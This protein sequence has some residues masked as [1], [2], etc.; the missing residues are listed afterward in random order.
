MIMRKLF[1]FLEEMIVLRDE[2]ADFVGHAEEFFPL[3]PVKCYGK[4]PQA[5]NRKGS[6]LADFQRHLPARPLQTF[7]FGS[8]PLEFCLQIVFFVCH[9]FCVVASRF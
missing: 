2:A 7:I 3:L 8:K 4:A 9:K 5:V 1:F 6:F